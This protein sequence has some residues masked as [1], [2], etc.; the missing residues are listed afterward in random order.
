M[1]TPRVRISPSQADELAVACRLGPRLLNSLCDALET[2]RATI[3]R[4]RVT[5]IIGKFVGPSDKAALTRLLFG[6][7]AAVSRDSTK[8]SGFF[9]GLTV[10]LTTSFK[11]DDRFSNWEACRGVLEQLLLSRS[12]LLSAK[13]L[14]VSYDFE[15]ILLTS[16][17]ITSIRPIYTNDRDEIL[18]STVVQT[19]RLEYIETGGDQKSISFAVDLEDIRKIIGVCKDGVMKAAV[20]KKKLENSWD[21]DVLMPGEEVDE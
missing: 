8:I 1:S 11:D 16:R 13:A 3:L 6:L 9:D 10:S 20:A 4:E 18:G 21:L 19:L 2:E 17:L 7:A 12:L 14:D 15:R 5:E